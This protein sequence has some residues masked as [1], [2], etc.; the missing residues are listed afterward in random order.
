MNALGRTAGIWS[1]GCR[2]AGG[3][4][5]HTWEATG[6]MVRGILVRALENPAGIPTLVI[7]LTVFRT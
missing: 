1:K 4:P 5:I 2:L 3:I 7:P 6:I